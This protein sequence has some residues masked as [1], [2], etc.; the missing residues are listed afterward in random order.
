MSHE[1]SPDGRVPWRRKKDG[2]GETESAA[3]QALNITWL[4][5]CAACQT[6]AEHPLCAGPHGR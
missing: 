2:L 3:G 5:P 6:L 1:T 4:D